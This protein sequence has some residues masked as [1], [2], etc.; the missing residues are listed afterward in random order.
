MH[1]TSAA[2]RDAAAKFGTDQACLLADRPKERR[3]GVHIK[4]RGFAINLKL[5]HRRVLSLIPCMA[6]GLEQKRSFAK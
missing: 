2:E 3:I 5:Y 1:G 4:F 6:I